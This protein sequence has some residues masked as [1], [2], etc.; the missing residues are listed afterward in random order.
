MDR[1]QARDFF[2]RNV[3]ILMISKKEVSADLFIKV[4]PEDSV[5]KLKVVKRT[6]KRHRGAFSVTER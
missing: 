3:R 5:M 6:Q 4:G 2:I 1:G